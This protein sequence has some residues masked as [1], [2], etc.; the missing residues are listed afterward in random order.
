MVAGILR[1]TLRIEAAHSL[2]E[3]RMVVRSVV[4]RVRARF[5][6]AAAE[7][8][9]N[10]T[11]NLATIGIACLSNDRAHAE[12]QLQ[13]IASAITS[14]RLDAELLETETEIITI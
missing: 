14:W 4:E 12:A 8:E 1:L 3:K 5:N 11:W 10:D 2:K 13:A 6:A 7:V 9:D